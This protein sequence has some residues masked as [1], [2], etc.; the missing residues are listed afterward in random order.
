MDFK[1]DW[2]FPTCVGAMYVK[3]MVLY[4]SKLSKTT[5]DNY[6]GFFGVL[7]AIADVNYKFL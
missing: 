4:Y 1:R 2:K 3:H 5:S 7:L 6:K